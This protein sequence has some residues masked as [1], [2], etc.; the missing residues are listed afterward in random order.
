MKK[1]LI[2]LL[3]S[4]A[5]ADSGSG[6]TTSKTSITNVGTNFKPGWYENKKDVTYIKLVSQK[7]GIGIRVLYSTRG[8]FCSIKGILPFNK[9]QIP[10]DYTYTVGNGCL[11]TIHMNPDNN[12]FT[13]TDNSDSLCWK[14]YTYYEFCNGDL[15]FHY[16]NQA[17]S[18]YI[19]KV[20]FTYAKDQNDNNYY[21]N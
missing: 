1:F 8:L 17:D 6:N 20:P 11:A 13:M 18:Y 15:D 5:Y 3:F 10:N 12:S 4:L 21:W 16:I 19:I 2:L 7:N 9:T 14:E